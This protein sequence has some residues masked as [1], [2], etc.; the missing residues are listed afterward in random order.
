MLPADRRR[1]PRLKTGVRVLY[2][3][4]PTSRAEQ[5][6][7]SGVAEDLSLGG[8]FLLSEAPFPPGSL[9]ILEFRTPDMSR[10]E[11]PVCARALVRW[12]RRWGENKGMGLSFVDFEGMDRQRLHTWLESLLSPE[13]GPAPGAPL[14]SITFP[15][16]RR[17][18]HSEQRLQNPDDKMID[19]SANY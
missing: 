16:F 17:H 19:H 9:V 3:G 4:L 12:R 18:P 14:L 2:E 7:L 1:Y 8:M 11:P 15:L 5:R 13:S 10:E 6:Y